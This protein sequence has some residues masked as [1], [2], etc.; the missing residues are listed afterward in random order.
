MLTLFTIGV[1]AATIGGGILGL[2]QGVQEAI[3]RHQ[4]EREQARARRAAWI[5]EHRTFHRL[6]QP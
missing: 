1:I 5:E 2:V 4:A 3:K 6:S